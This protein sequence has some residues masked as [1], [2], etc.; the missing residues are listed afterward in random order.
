[1]ALGNPERKATSC[2]TKISIHKPIMYRINC[3]TKSLL[4]QLGS[5]MLQTSD[6]FVL[7][8]S[9]IRNNLRLLRSRGFSDP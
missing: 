7:L 6:L 2:R 3:F 4:T 1:V 5:V 9:M 8:V